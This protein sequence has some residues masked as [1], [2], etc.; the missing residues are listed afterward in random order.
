[1]AKLLPKRKCWV[2]GQEGAAKKY[3]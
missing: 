2:Q 3:S 1:M